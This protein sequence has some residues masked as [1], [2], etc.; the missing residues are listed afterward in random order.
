MEEQ[1][2]E[3]I[4]DLEIVLKLANHIE[5]PCGIDIEGTHY[6]IRDFYLRI[7]RETLPELKNE[8]AKEFLKGIMKIYE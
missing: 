8:Y 7:A 5:H 1:N 6:D 4:T 2:I 3:K